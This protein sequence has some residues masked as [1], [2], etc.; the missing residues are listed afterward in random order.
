MEKD[1]N[2]PLPGTGPFFFGPATVTSADCAP[3]TVTL[4]VGVMMSAGSAR[5]TGLLAAGLTTVYVTVTVSP[6][7]GA[8]LSTVISAEVVPS[9]GGMPAMAGGMQ[10][11]GKS[12]ATEAVALACAGPASRPPP[13]TT[14]APTPS[15]AAQ[16]RP[17]SWR[18]RRRDLRLSDLRMAERM[19]PPP[20]GSGAAALPRR[21][22][23]IDDFGPEEVNGIEMRRLMG[24]QMM[25]RSAFP[26]PP[27]R[28]PRAG[29]RGA[30]RTREG[31]PAEFSPPSR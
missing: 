30:F 8:A 25:S 2:S 26:A 9:I 15:A 20:A 31:G 19:E 18:S 22:G 14:S 3:P 5:S 28:T 29:G 1:G 11:V 27:A 21:Q 4:P 16:R 6:T 17:R 7:F 10:W 12:T 23:A 24:H 13:V